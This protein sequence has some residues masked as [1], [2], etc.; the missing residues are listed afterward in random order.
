[1]AF[2]SRILTWFE[3][4]WH[5]GNT[6]ILGAA[7][8]GTW[9]GTLVFDGA[10]AFEG[11]TP[12]LD[13]HCQRIVRSARA[14]GM[15]PVM[16]AG[17]I[18][19][20]FRD[21]VAQYAPDVALYLRPMMWS[22][23]ASPALVDAL[24]DSTAMALCIEDIP[25]AAPGDLALTV[26]PY[27]RPRQDTA[28]TEA[29]A[30]CLYPNNGR[31]VREARARGFHNALS[32]DLDGNVAE[33]ASTNVFMLRDGVVLTPVPNGTFL[34]GITRA[35]VIQLLRDAGVTVEEASLTV[36][37]FHEAEEMFITGNA[38]KVMPVTRFEDRALPFGEIAR[39]ARRLYWDY[40]HSRAEAA[41]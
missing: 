41:Q 24:P 36:E 26:S 10:R 25:M 18:E 38:N 32:L 2:G 37:D 16:E 35:R 31:I 7:D 8:H 6:P 21:G 4:R 5:E 28:M 3:G 23:E 29:K 12:D 20:I 33:T 27:R 19:A 9:Q 14:M 40:A 39:T 15:E 13:L 11:V 17:E 30:A 22:T 1:M 34:A